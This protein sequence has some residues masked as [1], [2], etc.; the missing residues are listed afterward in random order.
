MT[1]RGDSR[2]FSQFHGKLYKGG[3][4]S[5]T[6]CSGSGIA[7]IQFFQHLFHFGKVKQASKDTPFRERYFSQ[8]SSNIQ[9]IVLIIFKHS[10]LS[11]QES[12]P[13]MLPLF[14]ALKNYTA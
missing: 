6:W 2:R 14:G 9:Y 10:N 3:R 11:I 13:T 1:W 12:R 8:L 7:Y 5:S 4:A